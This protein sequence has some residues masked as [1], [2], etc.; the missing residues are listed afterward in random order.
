MKLNS[1]TIHNFRGIQQIGIEFD[2]RANVIVGP[3]AVGKTTVLEAIR[4]AKAVL[5][6]R[7]PDEAQNALVTLGAITPHNPQRLN[8]AAICG[9]ETQPLNIVA[10]F[11]LTASEIASLD[12]L[13]HDLA[14]AAVRAS[15]VSA[16]PPASYRSCNSYPHPKAL[17]RLLEQKQESLPH[18]P[19]SRPAH[20]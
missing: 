1:L 5:A 7:I 4:L 2:K 16:Q 20:S 13:V 19:T 6:P 17:K 9:L 11:E 3:N 12:S 18:S 10:V 8:Y 15:Q 14:T